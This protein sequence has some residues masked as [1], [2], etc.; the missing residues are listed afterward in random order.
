MYERKTNGL[1]PS[2]LKPT[3]KRKRPWDEQTHTGGRGGGT[4]KF[5]LFTHSPP[6]T[7]SS[8]FIYFP[9]LVEISICQG[10]GGGGGGGGGLYLEVYNWDKK[11][12]W[13]VLTEN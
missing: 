13:N 5:L 2:A 11:T 7:R 4:M 9:F 1:I 8:I 3:E 10:M 6:R 12:F